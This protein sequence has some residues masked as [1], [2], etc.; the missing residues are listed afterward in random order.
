MILDSIELENIRSYTKEKIEFPKGITLFEGDIGSGKSSVLMAIE[1]ALF[2]L[3]SQKPE[4]LL[5]KKATDGSVTL[6]F[7]VDGTKYE[8][9]RSLKR[10]GNS[11]SQDAKNSYLQ[12]NGQSEPLSPTE[13]K[14]RVLQI[15]NFNEPGDPR[16]ISRIFRYAV[17]TPQEEMKQ[18][19]RDST[20]R[21]E[22]IRRAFGV[23]DYKTAAENAKVLSSALKTQMA[24]FEERYSKLSEDTD[25][26]KQMKTSHKNL[27]KLLL[28][29]EQNKNNFQSQVKQ[30]EKERDSVL[31]K[32]KN[33]IKLESEL[34]NFQSKIKSNEDLIESYD[35]QIQ[36]NQDEIADIKSELSDIKKIKK[37]T[38]KTLDEIEKEIS[39]GSK[40]RDKVI[41]LE[42]KRENL[43][44]EVEN[45]QKFLGPATKFTEKYCNE[46]IKK[47]QQN[48]DK[49]SNELEK[50]EKLIEKQKEIKIKSESQIS[51]IKE[52]LDKVAK[53]G[54]KCPYCDHKLTKE[55]IKKLEKE[56]KELLLKNEKILKDSKKKLEELEFEQE[57]IDEQI[58]VN[59][60]AI[61]K[62]ERY[63]PDLKNLYLKSNELTVIQK[64]LKVVQSQI[65]ISEEKFFPN[66]GRFDNSVAYLRELKDTLIEYQNASKNT[67]E[68]QRRQEKAKIAF[69]KSKS[70]KVQIEEK[71]LKLTKDIKSLESDLQS[72]VGLDDEIENNHTMLEKKNSEFSKIKE[73]IAGNNANLKNYDERITQI[74]QQISEA[75]KWKKKNRKFSNYYDWFKE[76]F[77]PT[78]EQIEKQVLLSIQQNFNE[79]YRRWYSIL[80][81][82]STKES[83]IDEEFSPIIEQDGYEQDVDYLSGGEK[84]S[85]A[86]AYRLTLNSM[87]RQETDSLKSNLLILDEPTDGFSKTQLSKVRDVL[88]ELKSQQIILVSHEKELETYVDNIFQITK[89]EGI[90]KVVR[91]NN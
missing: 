30:L 73:T 13:L 22:T 4:A 54:A 37:P 66:E 75:E 21:L 39:R 89:Q 38:E 40:I 78:V 27:E 74:E 8:I 16:A 29:L 42:S 56:R 53:L 83:R 23:E 20:I 6:S 79:I 86:L 91:L 24:V 63:L 49:A 62:I 55:H 81:D 48:L 68:L 2:G 87:M 52:N 34:Q 36:E 46:E 69:D 72:F 44:S 15:L 88:Q 84:T 10:K 60:D 31:K 26:L 11:V 82:D 18:I 51:I 71:N 47:Y 50:V 64:E 90:S 32:E 9:K 76:F 12:S 17:F 28:K 7:E 43:D 70:Q 14:Q 67:K 3:G 25:E 41:T 57:K 45:L 61:T 33:K 35:G 80:I 65:L 59:G 19:L 85:I 1:F 77:I 58:S 5:S